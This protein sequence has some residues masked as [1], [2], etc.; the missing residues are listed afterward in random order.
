MIDIISGKEGF[1]QDEN[2][3]EALNTVHSYLEMPI[4]DVT[5]EAE[6]ILNQVHDDIMTRNTGIDEGIKRLD[7]EMRALL[8]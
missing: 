6:E 7:E 3:K 4:S 8:E 5:A 1:P 2:S